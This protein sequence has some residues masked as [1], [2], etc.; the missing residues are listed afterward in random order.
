MG[1]FA[2]TFGWMPDQV[3]RL[4]LREFLYFVDYIDDQN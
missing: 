4:T 1:A 2:E 3:R